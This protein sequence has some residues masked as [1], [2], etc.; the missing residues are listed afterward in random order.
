MLQSKNG[1]VVEMMYKMYVTRIICSD[2]VLKCLTKDIYGMWHY[3]LGKIL[4]IHVSK[5]SHSGVLRGLSPNNMHDGDGEA[6]PH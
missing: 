2:P 6:V 3:V 4:Q 5:H 1:K